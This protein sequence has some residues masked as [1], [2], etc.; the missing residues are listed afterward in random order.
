MTLK[1][2]S[3]LKQ[4]INPP[5]SPAPPT[6]PPT[7]GD[8]KH[9]DAR[10]L[11]QLPHPASAPPGGPLHPLRSLPGRHPDRRP[12][13]PPA[14]TRRRSPNA[15]RRRQL[16]SPA[17][18]LP[19]PRWAA[20]AAARPEAGSDLRHLVPVLDARAQGVHQRRQVHAVPSRQPVQV[21]RVFHPHAHRYFFQDWIFFF[22]CTSTSAKDRIFSSFLC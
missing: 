15:L 17:V 18:P 16:P 5:P 1:S 12:P 10:E 6:P 8:W 2:T 22:F 4:V 9:D 14:P 19:A 7:A 20:G 21:P 3:A 11:L 13:Q